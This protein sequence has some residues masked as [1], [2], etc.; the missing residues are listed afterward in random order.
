MFTNRPV[1]DESIMVNDGLGLGL[2]IHLKCVILRP[3]GILHHIHRLP[4]GTIILIFSN[5]C[6]SV[7]KFPGMKY[8]LFGALLFI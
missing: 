4:R 6:Y 5:R 2:S 3:G 7:V 1:E 8:Q